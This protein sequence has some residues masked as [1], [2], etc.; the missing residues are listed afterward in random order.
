VAFVGAAVVTIIFVECAYNEVRVTRSQM[1]GHGGGIC[2]CGRC[3]D[4][5]CR[6][7]L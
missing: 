2:G 6:V 4:H 5:F 7:C 3:D 1:R